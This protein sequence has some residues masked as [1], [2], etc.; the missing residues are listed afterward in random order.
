MNELNK[1]IE[2]YEQEAGQFAYEGN[3]DGN[4]DF[5]KTFVEWL[6]SRPTCGAEQRKFLDEIEAMEYAGNGLIIE[7][8]W[9]LAV[10]KDCFKSDLEKVIQGE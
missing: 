5:Y 1:L 6:A 10:V 3:I 7:A 4:C 8:G 2:Q 9:H